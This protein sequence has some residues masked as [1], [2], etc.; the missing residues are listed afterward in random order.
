MI[1]SEHFYLVFQPI[2]RVSDQDTF[3]VEEFEVLL[4]SIKTRK[5]PADIFHEILENE[6][7]YN[8]YICWFKSELEQKIQEYPSTK[9]SVNLDIDQ[10]QFHSTFQFLKYFCQYHDQL[11]I[12]ITE[13]T[14]KNNPELL[15]ALDGILKNI[16]LC[17]YKIAID[18]YTEGI[19]TFSLYKNHRRYYDRVKITFLGY[20]SILHILGLVLYV[21]FMRLFFSKRIEIVV[22]RIDS[23]R[24]L[25]IAKNLSVCLQQGFYFTTDNN[26]RLSGKGDHH[27]KPNP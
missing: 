23:L 4:R 25:K 9:F 19:N 13:H 26:I 15:F 1:K 18:D 16:K 6:S 10:F 21:S 12:E 22:E 2:V 11:I 24:K 17:D 27:Y 3:L 8:K 5:F 7:K 20:K 14:P